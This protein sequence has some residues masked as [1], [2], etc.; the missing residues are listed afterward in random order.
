MC[1]L[2]PTGYYWSV[3]KKMTVLPIPSTNK[4]ILTIQTK[5]IDM[6][7]CRPLDPSGIYWKSSRSLL[8]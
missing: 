6:S 8:R 2:D 1:S 4:K 3:R 7:I 5:T